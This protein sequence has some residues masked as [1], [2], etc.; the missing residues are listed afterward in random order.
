MLRQSIVRAVRFNSTVAK[1]APRPLSSAYV[2][3]LETRWNKLPKE[4]Q[5]ALIDE[6]KARMELPWQEL[7]S[8]EK[9][10]AYYISFGEWGPRKPLYAPGDKSKIFW[11]T[12]AGLLAGVGLFASLRMMAPADPITLNKEWQQKS[13]EYLKSKNANPFTGYSQIQ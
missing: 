4:D 1:A 3:H 10:A 5:T 12:V 6:L 13:D 2:N 7:T 9:K 11:G 8:G